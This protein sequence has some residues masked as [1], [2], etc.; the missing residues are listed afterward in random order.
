MKSKSCFDV[1]PLSVH[2]KSHLCPVICV[3]SYFRDVAR[4]LR[5][6]SPVLIFHLYRVMYYPLSKWSKKRKQ[7]RNF[8]IKVHRA[9]LTV[10][11]LVKKYILKKYVLNDNPYKNQ[12]V[13]EDP[14]KCFF[15]LS[16]IRN[17]SLTLVHT[18]YRQGVCLLAS[19]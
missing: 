4:L 14:V 13:N 5:I 7:S 17:W 1:F 6:N 15:W 11:K 10:H 18:D 12:M 9:T 19:S 2:T 16:A 3:M 8:K